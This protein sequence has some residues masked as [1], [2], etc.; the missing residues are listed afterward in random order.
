MRL[1]EHEAKKVFETMH[2]AEEER[3]LSIQIYGADVETMVEAAKV[4]EELGPDVCDINMGC[5]AK[6]VCNV[7][8]GSSLLRDEKLVGRILDAVVNAVDTPVTLKTRTG[9]SPET[10]NAVRVAEITRWRVI[11]Q[12]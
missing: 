8:A 11:V 10:R 3:P 1:Y 4:V 9:W 2:F 7:A 5:P 12:R 6:K